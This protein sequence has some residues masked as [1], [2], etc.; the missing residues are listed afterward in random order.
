M[1]DHNWDLYDVEG[2]NLIE[3]HRHPKKG[4]GI[5]I[6]LDN[7]I[8]YEIPSNLFLTNDVSE[9][10]SLKLIKTPSKQAKST[11]EYLDTE[12]GEL[13]AQLNQ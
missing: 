4:W 3:V 10:V 7:N 12:F 2:Y 5:G 1:N 6:F 11:K 8:P 13:K 9:C